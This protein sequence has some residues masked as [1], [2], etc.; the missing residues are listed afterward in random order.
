[1]KFKPTRTDRLSQ[2]E[3]E[4]VDRFERGVID[5]AEAGRLLIESVNS[6]GPEAEAS[7]D[8]EAPETENLDAAAL[9]ETPEAA[10]ARAL[11][12]RIARDV[13]DDPA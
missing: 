2:E 12:E 5:A 9:D 8:D 7:I 6:V 3:R 10:K 4:I 13:Y 1:M 11:V